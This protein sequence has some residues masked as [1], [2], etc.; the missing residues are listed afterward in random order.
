MKR[1]VKI[2]APV[3]LAALV[4]VP[5]VIAQG[6]PIAEADTSA[7]EAVFNSNCVAC[8][9]MNGQGVPGAFP[10]LAGHLPE[11]LAADGA[12]EYVVDVVLYGLQGPITV[13]GMPYNSVMTPWAGVLN[14][15]QVADVL[16][17]AATAWDNAAALPEG[18]T[19]FTAD[20][21]AAQRAT[22]LDSGQVHAKREALG[23][24]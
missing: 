5:V 17:Y 6:T 12:R 1:L 20:E 18:F 11:V 13:D 10:P 3:L 16:N 22:P 19:A 21:V 7:G 14:D 2:L 9:M 4:L 23:L 24:D 8:H 15:Q